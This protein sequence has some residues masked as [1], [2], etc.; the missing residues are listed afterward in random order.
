MA[1]IERHNAVSSTVDRC[2]QHHFISYIAQLGAP[3]IVETDGFHDTGQIVQEAKHG[4]LLDIGYQQML[5]SGQYG[6][7]LK[8]QRH[9]RE[10]PESACIGES[11]QGVRSPM[12]APSGMHQYIRIKD[13]PHHV[14]EHIISLGTYNRRADGITW[15][16]R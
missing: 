9:A 5:R 14:P 2:L 3:E 4:A 12:P 8:E 13:R 6:F 10:H 7:V 11:Q 15:E 1:V 16:E